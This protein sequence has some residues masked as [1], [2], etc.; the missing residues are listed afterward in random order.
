VPV[1]VENL[2]CEGRPVISRVRGEL[3]IPGF[4]LSLR[5]PAWKAKK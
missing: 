5:K 3:F 4:P 1:R 2:R